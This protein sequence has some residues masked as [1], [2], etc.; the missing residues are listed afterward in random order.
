MRTELERIV[1]TLE[2][3]NLEILQVKIRSKFV[4]KHDPEILVAL[5][6]RTLIS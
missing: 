4:C 6:N 3:I 1:E 5:I 2:Q